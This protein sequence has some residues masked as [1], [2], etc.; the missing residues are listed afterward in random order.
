MRHPVSSIARSGSGERLRGAMPAN[1][2]GSAIL[3]AAPEDASPRAGENADRVLMPTAA[4]A[5]T[6]IHEGRPARGMTG[7]VGE[8]RQGAAQAFVAGPAEDH[9]LVLTGGMRDGRQAALG[10][11]LF[12]TGEARAIVAEL[13]EDLRGIDGAAT[14][15]ALHEAAIRMLSQRRL[16][17]RGELLE[18]PDER[19]QDS[20]EGADE[21]PA[22]LRFGLADLARRRR[23]EAGEQLDHGTAAGVG[24]LAE[25]LGEALFAQTRRAV[26]RGVAGQEGE[27]DRRVDVEKDGRGAGP[28]ALEQ[29]AQLIGEGDA[30]G[31][32]VIAA[33]HERP[34]GA[35][36]VGGRA[37][38]GEAM[39]I[40]AQQIRQDEGIAGVTLAAGG[41]VA[42]PSRL[43]GVRVDG[44]DLEPGVD[45]RVDEQARGPFKGDPKAAGAAEAAQTADELSEPLGGV[46][47]R[48]LP[49]DAASLVDDA[50]RVGPTR[51]VD[52]D[53]E[54][55]RSEER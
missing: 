14:R 17:G 19:G 2:V 25:E 36:L 6:L 55:H 28:D 52:A 46:R 40:Q 35:S 42:R 13:S 4:G 33:A 30:L 37:Q 23:A 31:D 22:G 10:G 21:V 53:E 49:T 7:V 3:P 45:E 29:G 44:H 34:Q 50:D 24:V 38:R 5:G 15:Q 8:G 20:H 43:E 16:D 51:P 27:R 39:A 12:V 32:E 11:E 47:Y 1:V 9:G 26:G 18:L 54:S 41:G 48:A